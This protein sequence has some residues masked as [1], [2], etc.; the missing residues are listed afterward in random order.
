[1]VTELYLVN[2][3]WLLA[4]FQITTPAFQNFYRNLNPALKELPSILRQRFKSIHPRISRIARRVTY[5]EEQWLN[6]SH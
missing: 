6:I 4:P 2:D 3:R 5:A 1:M